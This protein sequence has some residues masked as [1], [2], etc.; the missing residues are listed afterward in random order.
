VSSK[1]LTRRTTGRTT[2]RSTG[3]STGRI[4]R[5]VTT[6]CGAAGLTA[7]LLTTGC[8]AGGGGGGEPSATPPADSSA[9]P[10][11]PAPGTGD[12]TGSDTG[13]DTAGGTETGS[14]SSAPDD[15][16]QDEAGDRCVTPD[17]AGSLAV[18]EG[19]ASTGHYEVA[20]VLEN[21]SADPC[22][23]QGWPGVSF[24]GDGDGEQIGAAGTLDR[25][26]PHDAVTLDPGSAA[27][28]VVRVA[29]AENYGEE[30]EQTQADGFRVYPPGEKRSL[31]VQSDDVT[32]EAC[33]NADDELLDVQ[34]F[35]PAG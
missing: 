9:S 12:D 21:T 31:F 20:I 30:C 32:L 16:A 14:A 10:T 4:I 13:G 26:S 8:S 2:T 33:S 17:L 5:L 25:L 3:R 19:G 29:N 24:V 11:S 15:P 34:A 27:Q 35:R 6:A 23:L 22:V 7:L 1:L 28:A 18:V